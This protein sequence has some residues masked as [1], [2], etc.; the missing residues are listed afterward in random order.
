VIN[1]VRDT[2]IY[3]NTHRDEIFSSPATGEQP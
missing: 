2:L 1:A 3:F